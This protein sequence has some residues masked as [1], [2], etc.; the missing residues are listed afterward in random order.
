MRILS[1]CAAALALATIAGAASAQDPEFAFNVVGN[2]DYVFRGFSQTNEDPAI[3]GGVD[4]TLGSVYLGAWASNVDFGDNTDAEIDVY[5]G[6]RWESVGVAW[7]VGVVGYFYAPGANSDYDYIEVKAAGSRA[8]GPVTVGGAVYFSP[9][10]FGADDEATYLEGNAA[11]IPAEKWTV[12]GAVGKQWLSTSDDYVT[13]NAGVA[14][15]LT[16]NLVADVRYHDTDVDNLGIA[17]D[18]VVGTIKVLF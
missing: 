6:Y 16:D 13:W 12:S 4:M 1:A 10:F 2:S 17:S 9:D 5:G 11:F 14:Y 7:D 15:A 3:Q 18:R 8:I